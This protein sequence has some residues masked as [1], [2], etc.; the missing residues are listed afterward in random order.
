[1]SALQV[2]ESF[3]RRAV[4]FRR[5]VSIARDGSDFVVAFQPDNVVVFR[6][7]AAHALRKLCYQLRWEIVSDI[8]ADPNEPASW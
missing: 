3:R 1:M 5:Q 7:N 6:H 4:P 2:V 8:A